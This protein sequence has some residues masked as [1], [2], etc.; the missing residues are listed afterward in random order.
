MTGKKQAEET[1]EKARELINQVKAK[2]ASFMKKETLPLKKA[3]KI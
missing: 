1:P 3:K 2:A